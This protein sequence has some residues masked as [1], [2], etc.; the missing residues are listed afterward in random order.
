LG[1]KQRTDIPEASKEE[2][3]AFI[4]V[5]KATYGQNISFSQLEE[6]LKLSTHDKRSWWKKHLSIKKIR[7]W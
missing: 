3:A 4:G 6:F 1:A 5:L 7:L 2:I